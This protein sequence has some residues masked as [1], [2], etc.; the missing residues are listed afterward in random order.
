[1]I[2]AIKLLA[3]LQD[4]SKDSGRRNTVA[5]LK[6]FIEVDRY[7]VFALCMTLSCLLDIQLGCVMNACENICDTLVYI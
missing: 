1:M 5:V 3:N 2:S 7:K 4:G 6:Q